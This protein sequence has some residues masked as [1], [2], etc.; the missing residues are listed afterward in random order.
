MRKKFQLANRCYMCLCLDYVGLCQP[1]LG[2]PFSAGVFGK[3]RS[4]SGESGLW[5]LP[6][7]WGAYGLKGIKGAL[8]ASQLSVICSKPDVWFL[9]FVGPS[10][11]FLPLSLELFN[12]LFFNLCIC[13][14]LLLLIQSTYFIQ[15]KG[16]LVPQSILP[17]CFAG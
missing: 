16:Y 11:S 8:M 1:V 2:K 6:L 9:S 10:L 7:F 12:P 5:F 3:L 13:L 17:S 4:P 15:K 14:M